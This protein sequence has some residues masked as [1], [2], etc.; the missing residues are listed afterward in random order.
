[1]VDHGKDTKILEELEAVI[2][3]TEQQYEDYQKGG[4]KIIQGSSKEDINIQDIAHRV[5][6]A[7]LSFKDVISAIAAFDPTSHASSAWAIVSLGLTVC[8]LN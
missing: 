6:D 4:L 2:Q 3:L 1:M 5:L 8:L 7:T